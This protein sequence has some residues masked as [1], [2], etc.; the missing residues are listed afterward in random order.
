MKMRRLFTLGLLGSMVLMCGVLMYLEMISEYPSLASSIIPVL[1][2]GTLSLS[3]VGG[4][5][6][7]AL[8]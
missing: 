7:W 6:I 4:T 3:S 1:G 5:I 8:R 2:F